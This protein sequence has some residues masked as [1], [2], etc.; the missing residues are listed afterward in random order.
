MLVLGNGRVITRDDACPLIENGAVAV[1]GTTICKVGGSEEIRKAY[2]EAE[3]IDAKGGQGFRS[4]GMTRRDFSI[5]W[6]GCGGR[7]TGT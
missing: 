7:S 4:K 1:D 5:S 2:P 6:T 3:F